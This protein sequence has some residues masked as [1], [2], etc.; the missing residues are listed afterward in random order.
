MTTILYDFIFW[1]LMTSVFPPYILFSYWMSCG[2]FSH[3]LDRE[4]G[5][6]YVNI[7]SFYPKDFMCSWLLDTHSN[8]GGV[9]VEFIFHEFETECG[10]D[11]FY[12][13]DGDSVFSPRKTAFR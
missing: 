11:H 10:W 13:H 8:N 1:D 5:L 3:S 4:S 9:I 12:I 2:L 7:G 6:I